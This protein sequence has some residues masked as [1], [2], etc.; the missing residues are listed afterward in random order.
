MALTRDFKLMVAARAQSDPKYR[1]ALFTEAMS[2]YLAGDT[3]TGK[4][5][6]RDLVNATIGFEGLAAEVKKPSK[7]L[8]RMLAP[9]GNPTA[10]NLFGILKALQ[11]KT[12]VRLHVTAEQH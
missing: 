1:Q 2:A 10:E 3:R 8:H 6:L 7:S 12:R 4:A 5:V 11:K 9:H